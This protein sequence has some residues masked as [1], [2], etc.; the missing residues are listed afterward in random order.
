MGAEVR[1]ALAR[2][3][4]LRSWP[5]ITDSAAVIQILGEHTLTPDVDLPSTVTHTEDKNSLFQRGSDWQFIQQLAARNG[6]WIWITY[7]PLLMS[8]TVHVKRPPIDTPSAADLYVSGASRNVEEVQIYWDIE[9]TV[10]ADAMHIDVRSL[11]DMEGSTPRS[12]LTGLADKNLSD[13]V[14]SVRKRQLS[15]AV[16]DAGDLMVRSEAALIAQDWFVEATLK[17]RYSV[18]K[19]VIRSHSIV[20]LHGAG[21]RHSGKYLVKKVIH[22][23]DQDEHWMML[24]LARNGWNRS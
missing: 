14:R 18:I 2:E 22:Q 15:V 1:V 24:E 9:R 12:P 4:K 19:K 13:I 11:A 21:S 6:C 10:S 8:P 17:V 7:D 16:D 5:T 20:T 3:H 23:I